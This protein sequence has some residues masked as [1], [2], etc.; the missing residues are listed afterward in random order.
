VREQEPSFKGRSLFKGRDTSWGVFYPTNHILAIID[1]F[2]TAQRAKEIM[3]SAGYSED[4]VDAVPS[5]Y[6]IADIQKGIKN[7]NLL[8]RVKQRISRAIG[9]EA[10]YWEGDLKLAEQGAGFLAVY[11]PTDHEAERVLRLL[12]PLKPKVVRRYE[13]F[14]I[15]EL[16]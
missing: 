6:V 7:A 1:S 5:D 3:L 14:V 9:H 12:R 4:E 11:C 2:E 16:V 13:R 8:N 10:C 15:D